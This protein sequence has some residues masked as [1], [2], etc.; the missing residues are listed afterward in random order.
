M[1]LHC[2]ESHRFRLYNMI[3]SVPGNQPYCP[4]E[5]AHTE[6]R[7]SENK[8]ADA[9]NNESSLR[10]GTNN[11]QIIC[12]VHWLLTFNHTSVNY[13]SLTENTHWYITSAQRLRCY[14]LPLSMFQSIKAA[15]VGLCL[16]ILFTQFNVERWK[17]VFMTNALNYSMS[18]PPPTPI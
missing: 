2:N 9:K 18:P 14:K 3:E 1:D 6:L 12:Q 5:P 10:S 13:V 16:A 11:V 8:S 7:S 15:S 4:W 17:R